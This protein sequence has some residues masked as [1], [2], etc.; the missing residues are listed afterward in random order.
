MNARTAVI[1]AF[2]GL[3]ALVSAAVCP[4]CIPLHNLSH[5]SSKRP[6]LIALRLS[7][8]P[9]VSP[10]SACVYFSP[11]QS[12]TT[13]VTSQNAVET[14]S[15]LFLALLSKASDQCC[16]TD[17]EEGPCDNPC[18]A[19]EAKPKKVEVKKPAVVAKKPA[20]KPFVAVK[21]VVQHIVVEKHVTV[22][23]SAEEALRKI[24]AAAAAA[25]DS[26]AD[27]TVVGVKTEKVVAAK[28]VQQE[29][30]VAGAGVVQERHVSETGVAQEKKVAAAGIAQIKAAGARAGK[31]AAE[32]AEDKVD[33]F[34]AKTDMDVSD[35]QQQLKRAAKLGVKQEQAAASIGVAAV[36]Q[37][38]SNAISHLQ[39]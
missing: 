9:S 38:A 17:D 22:E 6:T 11:A 16:D 7:S 19:G 23:A 35:W 31:E 14:R 30:K 20:A 37:A 10:F 12:E 21:P 28:A 3:L 24:R 29:L 27:E 1:L 34:Q 13:L 5:M 26:I 36:Q 4:Q 25:E 33:A 2:I 32:D 39:K 15:P 8:H 18:R